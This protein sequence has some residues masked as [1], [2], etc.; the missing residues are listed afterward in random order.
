MG[1]NIKLAR[2]RRKFSSQQVADRANISSP[3]LS[4]IKQG[5]PTVSIGSYL[6]NTFNKTLCK[7]LTVFNK[8]AVCID[9]LLLQFPV[10]A[11][12]LILY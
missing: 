4:A 11:V 12:F 7:V 6:L 1:E 8:Y 5:K 9:Y 2:L 3:T 10:E